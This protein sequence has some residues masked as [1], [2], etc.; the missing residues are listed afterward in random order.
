M[1]LSK[2]TN[3]VRIEVPG[4]EPEIFE[5]QADGVWVMTSGELKGIKHDRVSFQILLN[6]DDSRGYPIFDISEDAEDDQ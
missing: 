1:K 6:D 4:I 3:K 2:N 5:K